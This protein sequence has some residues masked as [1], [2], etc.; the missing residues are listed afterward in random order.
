[1]HVSEV[2]IELVPLMQEGRCL[3]AFASI[4]IDGA[5]AIRDLRIVEGTR[6]LFVA[7][8]SR[9]LDDKCPRCGIKNALKANYCNNCGTAL[10]VDRVLRSAGGEV[11]TAPDGRPRMHV[12]VAYPINPAARKLIHDAVTTAYHDHLEQIDAPQVSPACS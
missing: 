1:M 9:K 2:K 6:G 8:P 3:K 12:D 5:L 4:V 11:A 7:M 10:A